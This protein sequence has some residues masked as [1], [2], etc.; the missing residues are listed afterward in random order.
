MNEAADTAK[1]RRGDRL[2][3][4]RAFVTGGASGI[5]AATAERFKNEGARVVTG[6]LA[7]G[8]VV[9]DVRQR[10]SVERAVDE[11]V[12]RLGGLDIA[13]C[14]AGK[15]ISGTVYQLDEADWD[16]G[17]A[18]NLKGVYLTAKAV[19]PHLAESRGCILRFEGRCHRADEM[20][21]P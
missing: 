17:M 9:L 13:V 6:D 16:D 2:K 1:A 21:G 4:K 8:D 7:G 10:G 11:A 19:W 3:G 5:G 18:T 12:E 15:G 14:N 20:H